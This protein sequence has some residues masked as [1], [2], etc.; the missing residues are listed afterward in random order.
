MPRIGSIFYLRELWNRIMPLILVSDNPDGH[1]YT[2]RSPFVYKLKFLGS[3]FWHGIRVG[4]LPWLTLHAAAPRHLASLADGPELCLPKLGS[5][6]FFCCPLH[7]SPSLSLFLSQRQLPNYQI[8]W[9]KRG[10]ANVPLDGIL[11]IQQEDLWGLLKTSF[12]HIILEGSIYCQIPLALFFRL[13]LR[14]LCL[15]ILFV[16]ISL[17]IHPDLFGIYIIMSVWS[18]NF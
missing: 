7:V 18:H 15:A 8:S 10:W 4:V 3:N 17:C 2:P 16:V 1:L 5:R 14:S 9:K 11:D 12:N 13:G 6:V